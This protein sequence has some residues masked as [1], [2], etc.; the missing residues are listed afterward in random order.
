MTGN[1]TPGESDRGFPGAVF[2]ILLIDAS[3][4]QIQD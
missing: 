1:V 2:F 3:I 4:C